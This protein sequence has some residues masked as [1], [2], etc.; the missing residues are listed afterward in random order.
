[1]TTKIPNTKEYVQ[2]RK[3]MDDIKTLRIQGATNVAIF[4]VNAFAK[5]AETVPFEDKVLLEHLESLADELSLV[6]VTE[7]ALRNGLRYVMTGIRRDGKDMASELGEQ[8]VKLVEEAKERIFKIGAERIQD[9][10]RVFTFQPDIAGLGIMDQGRIDRF[11]F[12]QV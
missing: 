9:G 12:R 3:V 5:H 1:M 6:R 7:P 8:Y 2:L 11:V 4:G 10:S